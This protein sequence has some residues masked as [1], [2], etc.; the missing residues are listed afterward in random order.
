MAQ[1]ILAL[2]G[3]EIRRVPIELTET[4]IGRDVGADIPIDNVGVSRVHARLRYDGQRFLIVDAGSRNG[5]TVNGV[6]TTEAALQDGDVIGV[7][8]FELRFSSEGGPPVDELRSPQQAAR[9]APRDVFKTMTLE[10]KSAAD[11][12][13]RHVARRRAPEPSP[14]TSGGAPVLSRW[15]GWALVVSITAGALLYV[16]TR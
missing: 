9:R 7:N 6:R 15:L 13:D 1:L 12:Y 8:K 10:A 5:I 2:R 3:R 11:L 16:L 4:T 14:V